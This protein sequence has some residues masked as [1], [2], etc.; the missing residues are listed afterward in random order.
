MRPHTVLKKACPLLF[1]PVLTIAMTA[2]PVYRYP[3]ISPALLRD[4]NSVVRNKETVFEITG[5][6]IA[7][8]RI[9]YAVTILNRNGLKYSV[10]IQPYNK[11]QTVRNIK[12]NIYE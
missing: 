7:V 10:F 11:F 1:I 2:Q 12:W 4:A 8:Q 5:I 9:K 3:D 6:G